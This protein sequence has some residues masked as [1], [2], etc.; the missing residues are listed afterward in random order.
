MKQSLYMMAAAVLSL[1]RSV[2]PSHAA[3]A[4]EVAAETRVIRAEV[5][6]RLVTVDIKDVSLRRALDAVAASAGVHLSYNQS[7]VEAY[8][9]PVT[10]H[11]IK[12]ALGVVI[13]RLLAGTELRVAEMPGGQLAIVRDASPAA[14]AA[15]GIIEGQVTNAKTSRPVR[16]ASVT[17]D[18]SVKTVRTDESGHYRFVEVSAGSHTVTV[19][20]V[21]FARQTRLVSVTDDQSA[22]ASFAL[23]SSVNT[24]DQVVVT[25]TGAQRY[26]ELGHVVSQLNADSLVREAPITNVAELLQS[27]VPGLQ[28]MTGNGGVAGGEISLRLRGTTTFNLDPEPIV[29][30]DGV[31]YRSNN[32]VARNA[33]STSSIGEDVRGPGELRSPLNDL[34]VNDIETVEVVKGPSASTLYGPDAANG[35]I[36]ITTKRGTAGKTE[37]H[38]YARPVSNGVPKTRIARG[39]Q[40]WGHDASG[41]LYPGNCTV[42]YQY[43]YG[44]CILDSITAA[45]TTVDNAEYSVLAKS[46]P[47]WQTGASL[48]GGAQTLRYYVSGNYDSQVGA[49]QIAPAVQQFLEQQL[50]TSSLS[51]AIRTPNALQSVG[52]HA[53]VAADVTSRGTVTVTA[54][55]TQT[56][57]RQAD[58]AA[59]TSQYNTGVSVPGL[60]TSSIF[61]FIN[62]F[63]SLQTTQE[64]ANRF[65]G[66]L[67]GVARWLPWLTTNASVGLDLDG[68]TTHSILPSGE[69]D[70]SDGGFAED[71]RRDNVNRTADG[72]AT[73]ASRHGA[74]STRSTLGGQYVYTRLDGL[75]VQGRGLAPGSTSIAT[76]TSQSTSQLW[77]ETVSLGIYGEEVFGLHDQLFLT[78]SLRL[79]GSTSLGDAYHPRPYPKLGLSWI[80]SDAPVIRELP[81]VSELR[82]RYSYG[83]ASRYPTSGMKLGIVG[84]GAITL[85]G[86]TQSYFYRAALANPL[87]R[88]E[89]SR[90]SEYGLDA[91]LLRQVQV[92]LTWYRRRTQDQLQALV[93]PTGLPVIWGNVSSVAAHGFEATA[94]IPVV[95]VPNLHADLGFTYAYHTDR[96]LSL[97]IAA[98][99]VP[100]GNGYAV[101]YPLGAIFGRPILGVSDSAQARGIVFPEDV[102]RDSVYR[103]LGV[104]N[105]P[106]S[107]TLTPT[108]SVLREH[109]RLSAVFDRQT[110]FLIYDAYA[111]NCPNNG[112]CLAPFRT[113]TP[114]LI[115]ARYASGSYEDFLAPGDFTRWRE[116]NVTVDIPDRLTHWDALHLRF[117][118]ATVSLQGR[119]LALWT[120]Y[121]GTDPESHDQ[122]FASATSGGIPQAR[123]WSLRFDLTP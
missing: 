115:Q 53:N 98:Q 69:L 39:Y 106:R 25:A 104:T 4:Q 103:F 92:G 12:V 37:F 68:G 36:I 87:L 62:P 70:P 6:A 66:A 21:G 71:D 109:V 23:E 34:N 46:R 80:A 101:G 93:N 15:R 83:A 84:G 99:K 102:I 114:L 38:W 90:E 20:L 96:V 55:Y 24:L 50:G 41:A 1:T 76:A 86:Q 49:L 40:A 31:R 100:Y 16:E 81:G 5:L 7:V 42:I 91:T 8:A 65:T 52:L 14:A 113:S 108:V 82:L 10:V 63:F 118:R 45:P 26:R 94:T 77:N 2:I 57:H 97:G 43:K 47:T 110:G 119:N 51:S 107:Y 35:V 61:N 44:A 120:A 95:S 64:Q 112:L 33:G 11:A 27:R 121:K 67:T 56:N 19:R 9:A 117:S 59:F 28:V 54:N 116:L 3:A 30:V 58:L 32:L 73:A 88:P 111:S 29:I 18:D 48:G 123:A 17:L 89:R 60:D 13:E 105:P 85:G 75:T 72:S 122:G 74:L 22:M 78:G 79:D